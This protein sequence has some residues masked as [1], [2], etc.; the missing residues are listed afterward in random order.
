MLAFAIYITMDLDNII[1][2]VLNKIIEKAQEKRNSK[3]TVWQHR[4]LHSALLEDTPIDIQIRCEDIS[5]SPI[6]K[7]TL[8]AIPHVSAPTLR[9]NI[10]APDGVFITGGSSKKSTS[11]LKGLPE[12]L[13]C[14]CYISFK[15][16]PQII[17]VATLELEDGRQFIKTAKIIPTF[18]AEETFS[19][20]YD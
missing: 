18:T 20:K 12:Y 9:L 2:N 6:K 7:I 19:L 1:D 5:G 13:V 3:Q 11:A 10:I 17:G 15:K 16:N 14:Y 4:Y 8:T